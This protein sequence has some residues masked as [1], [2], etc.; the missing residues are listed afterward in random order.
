MSSSKLKH[1]LS[2]LWVQRFTQEKGGKNKDNL[3]N[4]TQYCKFDKLD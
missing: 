4:T 1:A 3:N 2:L